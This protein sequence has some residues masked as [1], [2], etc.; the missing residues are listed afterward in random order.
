MKRSGGAWT[1][2]DIDRV[3]AELVEEAQKDGVF[4]T[5]A[6]YVDEHERLLPNSSIRLCVSC[7][8][9]RKDIEKCAHAIKNAVSRVTSKKR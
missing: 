3:L 8:H 5:R 6:M 4:L 7:S 9:T 1:K 2:T